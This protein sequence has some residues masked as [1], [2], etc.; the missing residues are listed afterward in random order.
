MS[1][2]APTLNEYS[3]V[4]S[5]AEKASV[6]T[7]PAAVIS[8]GLSSR[9]RLDRALWLAM[10]LL[11]GLTGGFLGWHFG[12]IYTT[13]PA[14]DGDFLVS[15]ALRPVVWTTFILGMTVVMA[16]LGSWLADRSLAALARVHQ[17]SVVDRALGIIGVLIGLTF[18]ALLSLVL[19][20]PG[21]GAWIILVKLFLMAL[22]AVVGVALLEG[23]RGEILRVF[24]MLD[25]DAP[26]VLAG[27]AAPKLIDTNI[28]IDGRIAELCR[29]GFI[30]GV[31]YVPHFVLSELQYIADSADSMRRARGRRG[32][33]TLNAMREI[34]VDTPLPGRDGDAG[35]I[36]KFPIVQ[37]LSDVS[38]EVARIEKV[39]DK[40][41]A[42]AREIN[43]IIVTNDFNLNRVAEV[44]GVRVLN[45]NALAL[46]M[47]PVV[48][49]GEEMV[50]SIVRE[51]KEAGQG[52]GYLEDGTMVVVGDGASQ[53]NQTCR[54]TISQVIQTVAGK[55]IFAELR[56]PRGAGDDL[57]D[58]AKTARIPAYRKESDDNERRSGSGSRRKNRT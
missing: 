44:Q 18:G 50:L 6:E 35:L 31:I 38:P 26:R 3:A 11:C 41:V 47:R 45:L 57:F 19:N 33:E 56:P 49:P 14:R 55:M 52:I 21:F 48:L 27:G 53:L 58:D 5:D 40:L 25:S 24:P 22:S 4:K 37:V 23:M 17:L 9:S 51:G 43:A 20:L 34:T 16:R 30:E 28:V 54:V 7:K 29:S 42:L 39:D 13:W 32:L 1:D 15:A 2:Q 12:R 36:A 10:T 8:R 46:A